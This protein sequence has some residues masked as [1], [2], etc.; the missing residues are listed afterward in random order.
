MIIDVTPVDQS[1]PIGIVPLG[2][3][4]FTGWT[5]VLAI[6]EDDSVEPSRHVHQ[7]VDWIGVG[8]SKP[9]TGLY[10]GVSGLVED[11]EDAIN[12]CPSDYYTQGQIDA[13]LA[14][15]TDD[16][17][18][19][20][21]ATSG[22]YG[23]LHDRPVVDIA[24]LAAKT[25]AVTYET[26]MAMAESAGG[27]EKVALNRLF[28]AGGTMPFV[29]KAAA[30]AANIPAAVKTVRT[31]FYAPNYAIPTTLV[32]G[33]SY[34]R[35][36][37][38]PDV[39]AAAKF[40]SLD[41]WTA[42]DN[43]DSANGG[44][45]ILSERRAAP[46]IF[47]LCD[48]PAN[49]AASFTIAAQF[50]LST[51]TKLVGLAASYT[52]G[53]NVNL[54]SVNCDF[55]QSDILVEGSFML[56]I[57][58]N[59]GTSLNPDQNFG[60]VRRPSGFSFVPA[61]L[62]DP[63][64]RCMGAKCQRINIAQVDFIQFYQSTDPA[65]FPADASQAYSNFIIGL[66]TKFEVATDP[67]YAGGSPVDGPGSSSQWWNENK[68]Y[69]GRCVGLKIRGSY[70]HNNNLF[71]GGCFETAN[72]YLDVDSARAN[73]WIGMRFEGTPTITFGSETEGNIVEQDWY[74]STALAYADPT[75]I[76]SGRLNICHNVRN[77]R[78]NTDNVLTVS[79]RDA[80]HNGQTGQLPFRVATRRAIRGTPRTTAR[81]VGSSDIFEFS[82][83][84]YLFSEVFAPGSAAYTIR[85]HL[86]GADFQPL[87]A[88]TAMLDSGNVTSAAA[89]FVNGTVNTAARFQRFGCNDAS[90]AYARIE[91]LTTASGADD[92][93][94]KIKV[95]R[96]S[97]K[98]GRERAVAL[99]QA[100]ALHRHVTSAPTQYIGAV[101]GDVIPGQS[102][103]YRCTYMLETT[104][105]S[106]A[107]SSAVSVSAASASVS[108]FGAPAINDLVGVDLDDGTTH[109][110]TVSSVSGTTLGLTVALPSAAA[111]GLNVYVSRLATR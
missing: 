86:F 15:K 106:G 32:G 104:L 81:I 91:I 24:G 41:R 69:L 25:D 57:G 30:A 66:A 47:G 42:E 21:V 71:L 64:I 93:A 105:A 11:I 56:V 85:I 5:P 49:T 55:S 68:I 31:Q 97:K 102:A 65:T 38:E 29:S 36:N 82:R 103:D 60:I 90:V 61:D 108:G 101:G 75:V 95:N 4:G 78:S 14:L 50:C 9:E 16:A 46:E 37:A 44:W 107:A 22:S 52:L 40:R 33:A 111:S 26:V 45:W 10:V 7:V 13:A 6:V 88:T 48:S 58:G 59:A 77:N 39:P 74:S 100:Y 80:I 51:K 12:L 109:W 3:R 83:D 94:T 99:Q 63:T 17:D 54:R 96:V 110:T 2:P 19:A 98:S 87:V 8:P 43:S 70:R 67:A 89:G 76:D 18:L 1:T 72:A 73:R 84:D 79:T 34:R 23:D 20:T 62:P 27:N 35:V 53:A 92:N 28:E